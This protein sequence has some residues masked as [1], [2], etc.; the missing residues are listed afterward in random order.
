MGAAGLFPSSGDSG[1]P[2]AGRLGGHVLSDAQSVARPAAH[3]HPDMQSDRHGD[4]PV[5]LFR[6]RHLRQDRFHLVVAAAMLVMGTLFLTRAGHRRFGVMLL[7][8]CGFALLYGLHM[9]IDPTMEKFEKT[10][11]LQ[12]RLYNTSTL[13]PIIRDYPALGVGLGN[14]FDTYS[15]YKPENPPPIL[16]VFTPPAIRTTTGWSSALKW[17][18]SGL[19]RCLPRGSSS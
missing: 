13:P 5:D 16:Q 6:L 11:G 17:A 14:L 2:E 7:M 8:L 9:G 19:Q 1:G 15:P 12:S 3:R 18:A 4:A 10:Q